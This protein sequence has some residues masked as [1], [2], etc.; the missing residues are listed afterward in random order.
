MKFASLEVFCDL[1]EDVSFMDAHIPNTTLSNGQSDD[2][3][4]WHA[5]LTPDLVDT[6]CK[7]PDTI[8]WST[9]D[10]RSDLRGAVEIASVECREVKLMN[11]LKRISC[12]RRTS[13][14]N[15]INVVG[16]YSGEKR[17]NELITKICHILPPRGASIVL[18]MTSHDNARYCTK[19]CR[20]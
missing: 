15:Q 4:W 17:A 9:A 18:Q 19:Y 2:F 6:T 13:T 11:L 12:N 7:C 1:A 5:K 20:P 14:S 3:G 10:T 8:N 16:N